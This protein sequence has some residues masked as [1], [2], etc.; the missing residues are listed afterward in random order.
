MVPNTRIELEAGTPLV[1]LI[2]VTD[3]KV[4]IKCHLVDD[5]EYHY[6]SNR[7]LYPVFKNRYAKGMR[8]MMKE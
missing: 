2:P 5:K 4:Q 7:T 3:K 1:H 8:K 6:V